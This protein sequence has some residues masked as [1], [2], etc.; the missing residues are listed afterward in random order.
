M[1]K[2]EREAIER[3]MADMRDELVEYQLTLADSWQT[4]GFAELLPLPEP[5]HIEGTT[6][7]SFTYNDRHVNIPVILTLPM[8][9]SSLPKI[10]I[11]RADHFV[12]FKTIHLPNRQAAII[13]FVTQACAILAE[14]QTNPLA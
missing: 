5:S 12:E 6:F 13:A 1:N 4:Q 9:G 3:I 11:G 7:V 2:Q 10:S 8:S 14:W